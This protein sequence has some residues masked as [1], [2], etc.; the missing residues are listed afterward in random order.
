MK[1][2]IARIAYW[3]QIMA[4]HDP[5]KAL[6]WHLPRVGATAAE[7]EQAERAVGRLPVDYR[8]FLRLVNGWQAFHV[9]TDLFGVDDLVRLGRSTIAERPELQAFIAEGGWQADEV[10]AIGASSLDVDVF[11][12]VLDAAAELP[13]GVVWFAHEEVDRFASF[14]DF[15]AS[16]V[17]YSARIAEQMK[18]RTTGA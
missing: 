3:K 4:E 5:V 10:I 12:L 1:A 14:R 2:D 18:A 16:M 7:I 13:G 17:N 8:E 11:L 9:L 6:P 15:L